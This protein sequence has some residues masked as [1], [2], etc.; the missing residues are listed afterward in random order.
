M[1]PLYLRTWIYAL[2]YLKGFHEISR[3]YAAWMVAMVTIDR[4]F[5]ICHPLKATRINTPRH[6]IIAAMGLLL[7]IVAFNVPMFMLIKI[8][9]KSEDKHGQLTFTNSALAKDTTFSWAYFVT[10]AIINLLVPIILVITMNSAIIRAITKAKQERCVMTRQL[11]ENSKNS[12]R[13]NIML[14]IVAIVFIL[15]EVPKIVEQVLYFTGRKLSFQEYEQNIP[16][17][18]SVASEFLQ[19]FN[20]FV[21]FYVYCLVG[22]KFQRI[23][24]AMGCCQCKCCWKQ[25]GFNLS[26]NTDS[27]F[28]NK[29]TSFRMVSVGSRINSAKTNGSTVA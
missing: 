11:S 19:N 7:L 25:F 17:P 20:S 9:E 15:C 4:Y 16:L 23:V 10:D 13:T 12:Q 29:T 6:A 2:P 26:N 1:Y 18:I 21:N 28:M 22:K 24:I 3:D 5:G 14:V 27:S 8:I